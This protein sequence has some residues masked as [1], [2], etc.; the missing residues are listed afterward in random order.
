MDTIDFL[1]CMLVVDVLMAM[2]VANEEVKIYVLVFQI[3]VV[4]AI[5]FY[6]QIFRGGRK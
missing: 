5:Y 1:L 3:V 6:H 2:S 4:T